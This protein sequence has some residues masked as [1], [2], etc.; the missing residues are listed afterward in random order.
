ME[1]KANVTVE[2]RTLHNAVMNAT[3]SGHLPR[4]VSVRGRGR[5]EQLVEP[6]AGGKQLCVQKN[7]DRQ[8]QND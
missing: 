5:Q 1:N 8:K 2:T 4:L 6:V 3:S 7:R